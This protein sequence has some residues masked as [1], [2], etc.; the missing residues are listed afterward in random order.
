MGAIDTFKYHDFITDWS[1]S[2]LKLNMKE[3]SIT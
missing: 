3:C 1:L 2:V